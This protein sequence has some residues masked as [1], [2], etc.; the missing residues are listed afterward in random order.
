MN[1]SDWLTDELIQAAFERRAG[2]AAPGD[3]R[4][5]ILTL[6]AAL[7]QRLPWHLQLRNTISTLVLS[8]MML[9]GV[10]AATV[11]GVI[12]VGGALFV[13][14]PDQPAVGRPSPT[15]NVTS[16]P[17]TPASPSAG[18]SEAVVA[19]RAA[20][21]TGTGAMTEARTF[22][23]ATLLFNGKVLV[24]GGRIGPD[25]A[26][27]TTS[28]ELYDPG[29]GTWSATGSMHDAR[30]GQTATRLLNGTV[31]VAG[32]DSGRQARALATAELY[33]PA[34][35]TWTATG[36]MLEPGRLHTATLLSDGRVLVVGGDYGATRAELYDPASGTW[37]ATGSLSTNRYG[38]SATLLPDGRVLV[39]GGTPTVLKNGESSAEL[40]DP[41]TGSWTATGNLG[42]LR[43]LHSATTLPDGTVL[44]VGCGLGNGNATALAELY[45]PATE[46]WTAV[47]KMDEIHDRGCSMTLLADGRVLV[48]GSSGSGAT[49]VYDPGSR[50]WTSAG[51]MEMPRDGH[52][53][54]LLPGGQ[55]LVAGGES[56]IG[57][58]AELYD[59]GSGN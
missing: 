26:D 48:A 59:P 31:L 44:V 24:A 28:A 54:T 19:P 25:T 53:A 39:V 12:V 17:S 57:G 11:I 45:D 29:S 32:G 22:H 7:S 49:D 56:V 2:R 1:R 16:S 21:W 4:E 10:A 35:G 6:S 51:N 38:H 37:T 52:T 27:S 36:D 14:R 40:Y 33:D 5:T 30:Y 23:T 43:E 46:S 9:K 47:G 42:Q 41:R 34:S 3:L 58:T 50:T 20:G 18:P 15:P 8:P 55:V 13:M